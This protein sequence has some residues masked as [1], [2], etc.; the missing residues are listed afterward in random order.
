MKIFCERLLY[1]AIFLFGFISYGFSMNVNS[2]NFGTSVKNANYAWHAD[3][4]AFNCPIN[5][6]FSIT[7]WIKTTATS[8]QYF[9]V[10]KHASLE[11]TVGYEIYSTGGYLAMNLRAGTSTTYYTIN[12]LAGNLYKIN[13]GNWHHIAFTYTTGGVYSTYVDGKLEKTVSNSGSA[14]KGI[15]NTQPFCIGAK[16]Q[17][18]T[19]SAG[20]TGQIDEVRIYT[21]ALSEAGLIT[22]MGAEVTSATANLVAA[23]NCNEGSGS[24]LTDIQG[25]NPLTIAGTLTWSPVTT[26]ATPIITMA[27]PINMAWGSADFSPATSNSLT[28]IQYSTSDPMV[29][30]VINGKIHVVGKGS[31]IIN[32]NQPANLFYNAA[33][34]VSQTLNVTKT[35]V[36]FATPFFE[37]AVIQRDKPIVINGSAD[38]NDVLTVTLDGVVQNTTVDATG[39]W[40]ITFPAKSA[41]STAFTLFA[42]GPNSQLTSLSDLLCGDVWLAAGQS[43]M[44]MS[45]APSLGTNGILDYANV[46]AAAKESTIRFMQPIDLWQQSQQP[47]TTYSPL[48]GGWTVCSPTTAGLYSAV[49]YFFAKTVNVDQNIPVGII[50]TAVGGTRIEAWTPL[51]GLQAITEYATWYTKATTTTLE[52]GQTYNRKNFPTANYNGMMAPFTHIPIKGIIWYQGEENLG[53]DGLSAITEY[54]NKFKATIQAW[55]NAW[56]IA[57]LPVIFTELANFKYSINYSNLGGSK[58][59]LPKFIAQQR[60]ATQLS[61]VYGITITDISNYTNIHPTDKAP[62]GTRMGNT[63]LGY[64]YG[65]NIVPTAATFKEMKSEGSA[66][67][68]VLNNNTGL[69]LSSGTTINEFQIAGVDKVY[70]TATATLNGS[71]VLVSESTILKPLYIKYAWDEN[72][73]PNLFNASSSPTARFA[74]SLKINTIN[75]TAIQTSIKIGTADIPLTASATSG[76]SVLFTSSNTSVAE[77]VN[78]NLHIVGEGTSIITASENG[79]T[80][81]ASAIPVAQSIVVEA[82]TAVSKVE[83]DVVRIHSDKVNGI[84]K[85]EGISKG[86]SIQLLSS[87]GQTLSTLDASSAISS[88]NVSSLPKG[89]YFV[90]IQ[91]KLA[92]KSFRIVI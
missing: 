49:A 53:I 56:G 67:R 35:K 65:K 75:F 79:N 43:N 62:V 40:T 27:G 39:K 24:V 69:Y 18:G 28:A 38:A 60:M 83:F 31:C 58:E 61:N 72:S 51:A 6:G 21:T 3:A 85:I 23:W 42:E 59:A 44:M 76:L 36:S 86:D 57:D 78:G 33:A 89:V 8:D 13:D 12:G 46:A 68:V 1:I 71:D 54:G 88:V 70:K 47:Q 7:A 2:L 30:T 90:K 77:I 22:D 26:L 19:T 32:A 17:A 55:R 10:K 4:S 84:V 14:N 20:M 82:S 91:N 66:L 45:I 15:T 25:T 74:D 87:N 63:A 41:K 81:Y 11:S 80:V 5:S 73:N 16:N 52:S 29:A 9:I 34:Q 92:L 37:H 48:S 64:I 50:Q